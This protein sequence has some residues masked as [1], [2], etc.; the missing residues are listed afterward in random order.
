VTVNC[1][2]SE[3]HTA[4]AEYAPVEKASSFIP[5]WFKD[6]PSPSDNDILKYGLGIP[7]TPTEITTI[8]HCQGLVNAMTA[9]IIIPMWSELAINWDADKL[10]FKFADTYSELHTHNNVQAKGFL[11]DYHILKLVS[12]W[13][14]GCSEP[15]KFAS[16]PTT[17]FSGMNTEYRQLYG[18][19]KTVSSKNALSTNQFL[20]LKKQ[21]SVNTVMINFRT[22]ILH[23]VPMN[24]DKKLKVKC[25]VDTKEHDRLRAIAGVRPFFFR[26]SL[27]QLVLDR[28]KNKCP[29]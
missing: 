9:G 25:I 23:Y 11:D 17:L 4:A 24:N 20:L 10:Q 2:I 27:K 29:L 26:N 22:P 19:L 6:L 1:F 14:L 13:V 21:Q 15:M 5:Q 8:K 3:L 18:I 7:G 16:F 28:V 12:P